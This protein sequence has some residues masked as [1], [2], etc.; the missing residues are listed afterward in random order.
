MNTATTSSLDSLAQG[1]T[2]HLRNGRMQEAE[3]DY[4]KVLERDPK[5]REALFILA[6]LLKLHEKEDEAAIY[7]DRFLALGPAPSDVLIRKGRFFHIMGKYAEAESAYREAMALGCDSLELHRNMGDAFLDEGNPD[8]ALKHYEKALKFQPGSAHI[9]ALMGEAYR[10]LNRLDDAL[11]HARKA[12]AIDPSLQFSKETVASILLAQGNYESGWQLKEERFD[13]ANAVQLDQMGIAH[14]VE[15]FSTKPR[16]RGEDLKGQTLLVWSEQGAGD[17]FMMMRYLP[18]L[19]QK[20]AGA[21]IVNCEASLVKIMLAMTSLV[22]DKQLALSKDTFDLQCSTMSLPYL[23]G[24]RLDSIPASVPYLNLPPAA[25]RK[26]AEQLK[27]FPGLK[28]GIVWAGNKTMSRD[29]LRSVSLESLAPL[30]A[31]PGVQFVSL[32]KDEATHELAAHGGRILDW[33]EA[34]DDWS[35]TAALIASLD[36]VIGV[37]T[38]IVHLAGALGKPVWLLNRFETEWR[39]LIDRED[40]PW[41]P[42]MRIFRQPEIHDWASAIERVA[43]ELGKLAPTPAVETISSAEWDKAAQSARRALGIG[44]GNK[45]NAAQSEGKWSL[46]KLWRR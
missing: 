29:R 22:V 19:K 39:W 24:T 42:T 16:W 36:L 21:V 43:A 7:E 31:V 5:H 41:Y 32:Q 46:S 33:M 2:L 38:A 37:D 20:G 8:E 45:E 34:C 10:S 26:W 3:I 4:R 6:Q 12:L 30:M 17:N 9:Y 11:L 27:K 1:A 40:S 35:D 28:V 25:S 15:S 14:L 13:S 18:L 44:S 23:F